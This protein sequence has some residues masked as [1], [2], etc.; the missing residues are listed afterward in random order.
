VDEKYAAWQRVSTPGRKEKLLAEFRKLDKKLQDTFPRF[1]YKQRV[2]EDMMV[3]AGNVHENLK[4]SQ[5]RIHDLQLLRKSADQQAALQSEHGKTRAL[6]QF[7]RLPLEEFYKTFQ[8]LRRAAD[9]AHQAKTHMAEAN[10]RLVVSVAKKYTNRGQSFLDLIQEGNIGLMKGVEKFEYRRGYKFSTYAIWWIRQ[11]ITRS[12]ADQARTIRIPVHMIEIMNKLWR[13]QKQLTQELGREPTPEEI[14][15]EMHMPVARI[16]SLLKMAQQPV[17]LHAPVGDDGDVSVGDFIEDKSAENPSEVTSYSLL[18]EKLTDVLTSLTE[19][20][21]RILE[22]RFGLVD[23]YERTLEEIGKMYSVT[24][25]RIRQI[26][27]K[28]LRK[29][30]HPTRVRHLQ[31]FLDTEEEAA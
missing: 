28:A 27:A 1:H 17:S 25:E 4:A 9:R 12:I 11:A 2:L 26:E 10:L 13:A 20:E 24:R 6:E 7:V 18:K 8:Q 29:L 21:R 14:A 30:R 23:G 31:G 22:M 3:V 5:K 16:N 15:D 19:R